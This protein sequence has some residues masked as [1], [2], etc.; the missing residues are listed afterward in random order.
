MRA[1]HDMLRKSMPQAGSIDRCRLV[2]VVEQGSDCPSRLDCRFQADAQPAPRERIKPERRVADAH[3]WDRGRHDRGLDGDDVGRERVT[4]LR[5]G[6]WPRVQGASNSAATQI[7]VID[8]SDLTRSRT[9]TAM[10]APEGTVAEYNHPSGMASTSGGAAGDRAGQNRPTTAVSRS[11]TSTLAPTARLM[12][13]PLPVPSTI[14]PALKGQIAIDV[15]APAPALAR[16]AGFHTGATM[17]Y[18]QVGR[19]LQE[20]SIE[21]VPVDE[22]AR[23]MWIYHRRLLNQIPT[24]RA[25]A[26]VDSKVW[27]DSEAL[28]NAEAAQ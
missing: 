18:A 15:Q 11:R 9:S 14:A 21:S 28:P 5:V 22:P 3:A 1:L 8:A 24:P 26:S 17:D 13:Q 2:V 19:A 16:P 6:D 20:Q 7:P 23:T 12:W 10:S 27:T 25:Q 4:R